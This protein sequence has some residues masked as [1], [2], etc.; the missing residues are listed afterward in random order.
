MVTKVTTFLQLAHTIHVT[1]LTPVHMDASTGLC[2]T[3]TFIMIKKYYHDFFFFDFFV[4]LV[5]LPV[6]KYMYY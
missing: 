6:M 2:L 4:L 1:D 3:I 5:L